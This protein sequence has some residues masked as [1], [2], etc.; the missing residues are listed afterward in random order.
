M[1]CIHS[2]F[3]HKFCSD[4]VSYPLVLSPEKEEGF[5]EFICYH[6]VIRR[7]Q[8]RSLFVHSQE[9]E[10][11]NFWEAHNIVRNEWHR[12]SKLENRITRLKLFQIT[13]KSWMYHVVRSYGTAFVFTSSRT[14]FWLGI[15]KKLK[16]LVENDKNVFRA[17]TIDVLRLLL[18]F[19][20][21]KTSE[22]NYDDTLHW[23]LT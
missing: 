9:W 6:R 3:V 16:F 12:A 18:M 1:L 11:G 10:A 2:G 19:Q 7:D 17:S 5:C 21:T 20:V 4:Q 22:H 15:R 13:N 14:D 8:Q 23:N